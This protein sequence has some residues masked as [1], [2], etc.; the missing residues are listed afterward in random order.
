[1]GETISPD[2]ALI[3]VEPIATA[4][5]SPLEPAALLIAATVGLDE[6]QVT[7]AVRFCVVPSEYVPMAVYGTAPPTVTVE[8]IGVTAIETSVAE[9]T[10]RLAEP[11][12]RPDVAVI[13]VVPAA[14]V[15]ARPF[16][17]AMLLMAATDSAEELQITDDV[18][19]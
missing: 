19:F 12:M 5:A 7:N 17:P 8:L 1:M 10:A 13:V 6:I 3:F 16:D 2:V 11:E 15:L 4:V 14:T 18:R 9:V